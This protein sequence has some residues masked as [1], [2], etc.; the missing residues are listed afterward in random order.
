MIVQRTTMRDGF[1]PG[2]VY[3]AARFALGAVDDSF[4][5]IV[6]DEGKT[7]RI[8]EPDGGFQAMEYGY[9]VWLGTGPRPFVNTLPGDVLQINDIVREGNR[10]MYSIRRNGMMSEKHYELLDVTNLAAGMKVWAGNKWREIKGV[11]TT[12]HP[13]VLEF[14]HKYHVDVCNVRFMVID[15][16]VSSEPIMQCREN[17]GISDELTVGDWYGVLTVDG[18][19]SILVV[20]DQGESKTYSRGRFHG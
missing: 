14:D 10:V 16:G 20:N 7:V 11:Q 13:W 6:N 18:D 15:G 8:E 4:F 1:T 9:V 17:T 3:G 5:Q 12:Q 2:K 19:I